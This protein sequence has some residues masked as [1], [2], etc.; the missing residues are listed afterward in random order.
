MIFRRFFYA[1]FANKKISFFSMSNQEKK[2]AVIGGGAAGFFAAVTCAGI[3]PES[4]VTIYE[5]SNKLLAKVRV[6]GGGRCNVTHACF[7]IQDMVKNYPRG[8]KHLINAFA[9]FSVVDTIRWFEARGV[10]LKTEEDGRMFPVTNNSATIVNCLL[11]EAE[12]LSVRVVMNAEL[13]RLSKNIEEKFELRFKEGGDVIADKVIVAAG[14]HPKSE[15]VSWLIETGHELVSPVPS[16]FTFN[17]PDDPVRELMGVSVAAAG[18]QIEGSK[19]VIT[20]PLLITHWGMSGPVVLKT[21]AVA[22]RDLA[23]RKYH[24]NLIVNWMVDQNQDVLQKKLISFKAKFGSK[25]I[26]YSSPFDLPKRLWKFLLNKI[27]IQETTRWADLSKE[28]IRKLSDI[29]TQDRY[30]VRGKTTFKEEFVTSGGVNLNDV[31]FRTME[32]RKCKGIYFAG[33][34][35]DVD[36]L[37]GGFN[38]QAAWTTG[39]IAGNS[40]EKKTLHD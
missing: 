30:E 22:A 20:G 29:L 19:Q 21:S 13:V 23:S 3:Y 38:F 4:R 8:E 24:F 11:N 1:S 10:M 2:I 17:M 37:T 36:G 7:T 6:S 28:F 32:S 18:L 14:G 12:K 35:L 39:H 27:G 9:R 31:D 15:H 40:I 34:I 33:E 16:L 5:R 25:E 26:H